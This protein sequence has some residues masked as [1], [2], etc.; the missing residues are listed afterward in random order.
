MGGRMGGTLGVRGS[1]FCMG[2]SSERVKCFWMSAKAQRLNVDIGVGTDIGV[3]T[4]IVTFIVSI[5]ASR[6]Q[7]A[8]SGEQRASQHAMAHH[9]Y[10]MAF[11][12]FL[13]CSNAQTRLHPSC[14]LCHQ[15]AV[16][17]EAIAY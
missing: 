12:I 14:H 13:A 17:R 9:A 2:G 4:S 1:F 5:R 7:K 15:T 16:A 3:H 11:E 8:M 10:L 6:M